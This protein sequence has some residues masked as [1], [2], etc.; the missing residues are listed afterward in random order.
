[1]RTCDDF[2]A[3]TFPQEDFLTPAGYWP[4]DVVYGKQGD[5]FKIGNVPFDSYAHFGAPLFNTSGHLVGISYAPSDAWS[6]SVLRG[7][8]FKQDKIKS[9]LGSVSYVLN[10]NPIPPEGP[11]QPV[12]PTPPT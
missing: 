10:G 11:A 1:M 8:V 5:T 7:A 4:G 3:F 6:V 2:S 12:S 9:V